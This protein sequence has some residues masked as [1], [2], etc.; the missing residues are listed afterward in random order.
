MVSLHWNS[1]GK[2]PQRK[3]KIRF[4]VNNVSR[5]SHFYHEGELSDYDQPRVLYQRVM[6]QQV[7]GNFHA[8]T[9]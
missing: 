3:Q 2:R 5:K 7:R 1:L 9:V 4:I 6:T 8:N